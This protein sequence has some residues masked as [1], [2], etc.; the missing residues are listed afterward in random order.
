MSFP[1]LWESLRP[2]G[3]HDG[4]GGYRRF[5]WTPADAACRSWFFKAAAERGLRT[6]T[7]R[8]ANLWAWWDP[9]PAEAAPREPLVTAREGLAAW[10]PGPGAIVTGSHLDS[11][12][13]GGAF[14][15]PLGVVTAFAAID[16]L[17][18]RGHRPW[19][20]VAVAAF[21][22]EEGARFGVAC[23]GSRLLT[24]A[25][26]PAR[27]RAL[28]DAGGTTFAAAM[29]A[30]GHDPGAMGPDEALL[31]GI[32]AYVEL[33]IEQGR[34]L[35]DLGAAVGLASGIW[36]HGRWR[37]AFTGRA[38]HA[39]TTRLGDRR[40]PML[41]CAAAILAARDA[42][43]GHAGLAT[44]GKL[45]PE[46]GGVNGISS[47]VTAWLDA[48][49]PDELTLHALVGQVLA[50]A[51]A[52]AVAHRVD[53]DTSQ[54][55]VTPAVEFHAGLRDRLGGV[56]GAGGTGAPVLG[57]GAGHDAGVLAARVPAAMLF[58]RNPSGVSHSPAEHAE[59]ADCLA[60]VA[61]LAAV[62]EDLACR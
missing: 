8:N 2:V 33:H 13:D 31:A 14:D 45:I 10:S 32:A 27:A 51:R 3:R 59:E 60:G 48:R 6:S 21:T 43:A 37:L 20:P 5:S 62:L 55:S 52:A 41:P 1:A 36:P 58:V 30:A 4:T 47:R 38:D 18:G 26:D 56:L 34:A 24:G 16:A 15:G 35:D 22:E 57:T 49:A 42:A 23:L 12:P 11:V 25:I 19:R 17:R 46:P 44:V 61:A 29:A 50:A 53:L 28:T 7:D 9:P 40:D 54:E 39:G